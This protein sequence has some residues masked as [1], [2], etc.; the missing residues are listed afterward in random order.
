MNRSTRSS[1]AKAVVKPQES[2]ATIVWRTAALGLAACGLVALVGAM[3]VF[4]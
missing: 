1:R 3:G 2:D 4:G